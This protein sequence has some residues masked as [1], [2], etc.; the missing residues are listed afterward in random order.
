M[1]GFGFGGVGL[2]GFRAPVLLRGFRLLLAFMGL[3][4]GGFVSILFVYFFRGV[5]G[6]IRCLGA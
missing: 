6:W 5:W 3:G 2:K 4:L 1:S